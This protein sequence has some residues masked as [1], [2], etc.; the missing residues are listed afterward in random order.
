M[1]VAPVPYGNRFQAG[2]AS[3]DARRVVR[4]TISSRWSKPR[5]SKV[6]IPCAGRDAGAQRLDLGLDMDRG[7]SEDRFRR[8][9][10][11]RA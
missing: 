5:Y 4:Q 7:A 9:A 8:H 10:V 6:T 1:E 2:L 11:F 3:I